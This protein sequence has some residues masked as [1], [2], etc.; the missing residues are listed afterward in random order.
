MRPCV[1][2]IYGVAL[3]FC[4]PSLTKRQ[5]W[6]ISIALV[7]DSLEPT[8]NGH[9]PAVAIIAF[10]KTKSA[11]PDVRYCGDVVRIHRVK[12]QKWKGDVQLMGGEG[13]S[14][15]VFRQDYSSSSLDWIVRSPSKK[16][17]VGEKDEE[18]FPK[19]WKWGQKRIF[20]YATIKSDYFWNMADVHRFSIDSAEPDSQKEG[21]LTVMVTAM[22]ESP[23]TSGISAY[24][25]LRVWD[26]TGA[27]SSEPYLPFWSPTAGGDPP[28]AAL[29]NLSRVVMSLRQMKKYENLAV[30]EAVTGRVANV[31][32]WEKSHW[33][34]LVETTQIGSFIRLR[35][36]RMG[37]LAGG[38]RCLMLSAKTHV[39]PLPSLTYEVAEL[40]KAHDER[41]KLKDP[42]NPNSGVLPLSSNTTRDS[43]EEESLEL[44]GE[45][46][47]SASAAR[48]IDENK[49]TSSL[50]QFA[51]S[52]EP[53]CFVGGVK[54]LDT[55]P[56][57]KALSTSE[58][59]NTFR[60]QGGLGLRL[61][62]DDDDLECIDVI[63]GLSSSAAQV[64]LRT[65]GEHESTPARSDALS[66]LRETI[67]ERRTWIATIFCIVH[68]GERFFQLDTLEASST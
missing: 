34:L 47:T 45:H 32:V 58:L 17:S 50:T 63:V 39:T 18:R 46:T 49:T 36:V 62:G 25:F 38:Q 26:G 48:E 68:K 16:C 35:N 21:D 31:A 12:V 24:G 65:L 59:E 22:I 54:I 37:E 33:D 4:P 2:N 56:S 23:T 20:Q 61:Q 6:M 11:L 13:T 19:L 55:F 66:H 8:F 64:L 42:L 43:R 15:L 27:P 41:L 40:I 10:A 53:S 7:D 28:P 57:I 1:V 67:N 3:G 29:S 5:Q 9:V 30:P 52:P 14:Y 51:A 60:S 44:E